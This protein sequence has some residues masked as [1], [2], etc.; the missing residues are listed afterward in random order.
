MTG[1][2]VELCEQSDEENH[3]SEANSCVLEGDEVY[4][5]RLWITELK[6]ELLATTMAPIQSGNE[7]TSAATTMPH[8]EQTFN[9]MVKTT[10]NDMALKYDIHSLLVDTQNYYN[11]MQVHN[12]IKP[13]PYR[14]LAIAST[15]P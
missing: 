2:E 6:K 7:M 8:S 3:V 5:L 15:V 10:Q 13:Q 1:E 11:A 9:S 12:D 14:Q 4:R